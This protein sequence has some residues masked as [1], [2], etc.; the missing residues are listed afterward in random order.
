MGTLSESLQDN[1]RTPWDEEKTKFLF[2]T[3][4]ER[5][6]VSVASSSISKPRDRLAKQTQGM[7]VVNRNNAAFRLVG[8]LKP[9]VRVHW[10]EGNLKQQQ[11]RG[12]REIE[13][14]WLCGLCTQ[15]CGVLRT[16]AGR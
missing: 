16:L 15:A 2:S 12:E 10:C 1:S 11:H 6:V 3:C 9:N 13:F 5:F 8:N 7:A 4:L 14:V